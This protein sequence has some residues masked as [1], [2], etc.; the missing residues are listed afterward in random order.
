MPVLYSYFRM[1]NVQEKMS[2][3]QGQMANAMERVGEAAHNV[4]QKVSDFFQGNPFETP[5]GRKIGITNLFTNI[6]L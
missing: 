5:V 3:V 1:S 4:G 2:N 6:Y